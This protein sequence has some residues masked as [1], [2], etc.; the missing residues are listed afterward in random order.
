MPVHPVLR[1][2]AWCRGGQGSRLPPSF[3]PR[4]PNAQPGGE[5]MLGGT[6]PKYYKGS[7][8]YHNVTRMAYWQ[9]HMDQ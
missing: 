4:D 2:D 5:L 8:I 1:L 9:V 6:D 3:P 7:L